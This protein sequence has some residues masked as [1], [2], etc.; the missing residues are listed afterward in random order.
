MSV[1]NLGDLTTFDKAA[2][3][4]LSVLLSTEIIPTDATDTQLMEE[5]K[6]INFGN[7]PRL[8][9][10]FKRLTN[11]VQTGLLHLIASLN[12]QS[13]GQMGG[14][15]DIIEMPDTDKKKNT[16]LNKNLVLSVLGL[17]F[18]LFLLLVAKNMATSLGGDYGLEI[19]F[20]GFV[21]LFLNPLNS[22]KGTFQVIV[23]SLLEQT[24][25]EISFQVERVCGAAGGGWVSNIL[26]TLQGPGKQFECALDVGNKIMG[27]EFALHQTKIANN[28][29]SITNLVRGG[30]SIACYSGAKTAL[31]LDGPSGKISTFIKN[32]PGGNMALTILGASDDTNEQ[33]AIVNGG[34]KRKSKKS[35]KGKKSSKTR[36]GRNSK[37][38]RKGRKSK[39]SRK[40]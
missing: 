7:N 20:T 1:F 40:A 6:N 37:K 4:E 3:K 23:N 15:T 35:R 12:F 16:Y 14:D 38:A 21:G 32:I 19:N 36:R 22:A 18:G 25:D 34:G 33:L 17:F 31:I 11:E 2:P 5:F 10:A 8:A 29:S 26:I 9:D 24:K 39:K 28:I 27:S 13:N 30:Y